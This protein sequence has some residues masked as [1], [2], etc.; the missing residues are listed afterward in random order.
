MRTETIKAFIIPAA[1]FE[2][3]EALAGELR[4]F[5]RERLARHEVPRLIEFVDSLPMTNTGKI[6]RRKLRER[7]PP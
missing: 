5:V 6:M 7:E 2:G 1:G 4:E 3:S